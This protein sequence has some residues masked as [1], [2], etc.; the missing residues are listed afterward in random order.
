VA[1][2]DAPTRLASTDNWKGEIGTHNKTQK[3]F[4]RLSDHPRFEDTMTAMS[5]FMAQSQPV[6][7]SARWE[8]FYE[9]K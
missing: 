8:F 6:V 3:P 4:Q 2:A 5:A 7:R 1:A 9:W